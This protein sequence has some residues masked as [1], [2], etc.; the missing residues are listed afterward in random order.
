MFHRAAVCD[1]PVLGDFNGEIKPWG[2]AEWDDGRRVDKPPWWSFVDSFP[3]NAMFTPYNV[4]ALAECEYVAGAMGADGRGES[5]PPRIGLWVGSRT[6]WE[7]GQL[8][9]QFDIFGVKHAWSDA[10]D[11]EAADWKGGWLAEALDFLGKD[12]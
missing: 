4:G 2:I 3:H 8:R 12:L 9:E 1:V 10:F 11:D 6:K 5:S 7:M